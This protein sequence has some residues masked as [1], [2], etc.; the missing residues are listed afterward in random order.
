MNQH[1]AYINIMCDKSKQLLMWK[2]KI[3]GKQI[4]IIYSA[5]HQDNG[6]TICFIT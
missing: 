6:Q 2:L 5:L 1:K 4:D 3:A